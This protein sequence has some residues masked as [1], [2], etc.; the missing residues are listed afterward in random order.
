LFD[1]KQTAAE[2]AAA[3]QKRWDALWI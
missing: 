2:T 3:I 1:E